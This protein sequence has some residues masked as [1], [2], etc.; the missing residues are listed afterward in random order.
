MR[1]KVQENE[2]KRDEEKIGEIDEDRI[3]QGV[4]QR[5]EMK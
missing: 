5:E 3:G 4:E 1:Q 2:V